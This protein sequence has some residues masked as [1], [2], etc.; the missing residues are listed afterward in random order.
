MFFTLAPS[1]YRDPLKLALTQQIPI[2]IL[3]AGVLDGGDLFR[4]CLIAFLAFWV[5][6][7]LIRHRRPETPTK[8]DVVVI[9][10]SYIPLG[11]MTFVLVHWFWKLRGM[12]GL[13]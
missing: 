7:F 1:P 9:K 2:L 13:R 4:I 6:A 3:S 12:P 10:W 8:L 11:I 5:G